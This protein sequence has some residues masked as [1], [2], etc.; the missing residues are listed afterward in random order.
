M[1]PISTVPRTDPVLYWLISV[2]LMVAA[3]ITIGGITRLTGSGL[4]MVDWRPLMGTIPPV[5]EEQWAAVFSQYQLFPQYEQVNHWMQLDDFKRIFFWEYLHRLFGRLIGIVFFLPMMWFIIK[6]D[7]A[8]KWIPKALMAFTLG[9]LQ[10]IL[11]WY[12]VKSGLVDE[13]AVSHYRLTA[14]LTLAFIIGGYLWWLFL[15]RSSLTRDACR[16][17][18][19]HYRFGPILLSISALQVVYGGLMAGT[20]AGFMYS[21]FPD[22]NG[23]F[24]PDGLFALDSLWS[25]LVDNP[26]C[27]HFVHRS[28]G[29]LLLALGLWVGFQGSHHAHTRWQRQASRFLM[30]ALSFQ[31]MVG[32]ATVTLEI[33]VAVGAIHQVGAFISV[34]AILAYMHAHP[35]HKITRD[36][37]EP[38]IH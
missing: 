36:N 14:H 13:P 30:G 26:I 27:I 23:T 19:N 31:F 3:M 17:S 9:G 32:V 24:V 1:Q 34:S 8:G 21:T 20:R 5:T 15:E 35:R 25:N 6:E 33:P 11:G 29:W 38:A 4:S 12:M 16:T 28:L 37:P 10:G 2:Y 7:L 22:M 18:A